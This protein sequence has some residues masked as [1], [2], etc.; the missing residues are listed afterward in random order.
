MEAKNGIGYKFP[1]KEQAEH[2]KSKLE[3][4]G[5]KVSIH[6]E[7]NDFVAVVDRV[8]KDYGDK[9]SNSLDTR[10][11]RAD[12]FRLKTNGIVET[13]YKCLKCGHKIS[14][15]EFNL[16]KGSGCPDCGGDL[17]KNNAKE[18]ASPVDLSR[19]YKEGPYWYIDVTLSGGNITKKKFSS[20]QEATNWMKAEKLK[21]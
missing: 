10:Q 21:V 7:G 3:L 12:A 4:E 13:E 16:L 19:P 11:Q 15:K 5:Y 20:E 18:N 6:S 14:G 9:K 17:K 1:T 2:Y 8:P